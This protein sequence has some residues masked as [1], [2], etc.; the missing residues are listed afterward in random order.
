M[1][2]SGRRRQPLGKSLLGQAGT[3]GD[4]NDAAAGGGGFEGQKGMARSGG[5]LPGRSP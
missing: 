5:A 3:T 1:N 4:F 2:D